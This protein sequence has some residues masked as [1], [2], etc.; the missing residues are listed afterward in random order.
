MTNCHWILNTDVDKI[1]SEGGVALS[2]R[3]LFILCLCC[4]EAQWGRM[5]LSPPFPNSLLLLCL[6]CTHRL[7]VGVW[8]YLRPAPC[9]YVVC[10]VSHSDSAWGRGYIPAPPLV[11]IVCYVAHT[12]S[13]RGRGYISSPPLVYIVCYV[14]NTDSACLKADHLLVRHL[15][16]TEGRG[17]SSWGGGGGASTGGQ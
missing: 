2:S 9:L 1:D 6:C 4:T 8:L 3:P 14:A 5:A 7:S 10:Y 12:D 16:C 15:Y 11:Y 17:E 13:A